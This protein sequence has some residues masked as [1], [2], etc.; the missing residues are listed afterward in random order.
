VYDRPQVVIV[1]GGAYILMCIVPGRAKGGTG[2]QWKFFDCKVVS[3]EQKKGWI[4]NKEHDER[5]VFGNKAQPLYLYQQKKK[6]QKDT[7]TKQ[8]PP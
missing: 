2:V 4:M 8:K 5:S 3:K 7:R 1:E 6:D